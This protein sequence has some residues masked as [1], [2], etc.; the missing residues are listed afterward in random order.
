M[1]NQ[2]PIL[3]IRNIYLWINLLRN[4]GLLILLKDISSQFL[5]LY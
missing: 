2:V 5:P 3:T 4:T 1:M